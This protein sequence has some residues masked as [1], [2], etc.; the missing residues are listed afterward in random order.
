MLVWQE[1][2]LVSSIAPEHEDG[3]GCWALLPVLNQL[4]SFVLKKNPSPGINVDE[5]IQSWYEE[6]HPGYVFPPCS[7]ILIC[8]SSFPLMFWEGV[9]VL[10]GMEHCSGSRHALEWVMWD[11]SS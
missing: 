2:V 4:C 7:L 5:R 10:S 11:L 8:F 6:G 3:V 1:L 9:W